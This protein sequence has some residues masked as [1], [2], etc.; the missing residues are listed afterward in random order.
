ME[1]KGQKGEHNGL[2]HILSVSPFLWS[3]IRRIANET[4]WLSVHHG[5]KSDER[6][7]GREERLRC[8]VMCRWIV[9]SLIHSFVVPELK[10]DLKVS[11]H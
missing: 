1:M 7:G 5:A 3:G 10:P 2:S 6:E 11:V 9:R 4:E 8:N